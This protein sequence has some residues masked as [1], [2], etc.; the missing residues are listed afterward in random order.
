MFLPSIDYRY[1]SNRCFFDH[2]CPTMSILM[3]FGWHYFRELLNW[4]H[5]P[6]KRAGCGEP[7]RWSCL[8]QTILL[9]LH[10]LGGMT[11]YTC[12]SYRHLFSALPLPSRSWLFHL[13]Q[14]QNKYN[15]KRGSGEANYI[16]ND[17]I[18][19]LLFNILPLFDLLQKKFLQT[20]CAYQQKY[21]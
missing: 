20:G 4:W 2:R 6:F 11:T 12:D 15:G 9:I 3:A 17:T 19:L 16:S 8:L 21:S 18:C 10:R 5:S 7:S 14:F 1:R 13:G